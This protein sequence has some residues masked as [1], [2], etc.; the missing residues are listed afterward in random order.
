[1]HT[2]MTQLNMLHFVEELFSI[3]KKY[4]NILQLHTMH[5]LHQIWWRW[6][7]RQHTWITKTTKA[8]DK[9]GFLSMALMSYFRPPDKSV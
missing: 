4:G 6:R 1:M 3:D 2:F 8:Q 7:H 9:L 5:I